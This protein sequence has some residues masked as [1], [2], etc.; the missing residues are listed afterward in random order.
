MKRGELFIAGDICAWDVSAQAFIERLNALKDEGYTAFTVFIASD[1]GDV[2]QAIAIYNELKALDDVR[3]VV[4]GNAFSAASFIAMASDD[5]RMTNNS[6]MLIHNPWSWGAGDAA[7]MKKVADELEDI[8]GI[9]V[10]IYE[11]KTGQS[12]EDIRAW[13]DEDKMMNPET[14]KGR[15]FVDEVIEPKNIKNSIGRRILNMVTI[16]KDEKEERTM[17]LKKMFIALFGLDLVAKAADEDVL[18]AVSEIKKVQDKK[19]VDLE[20]DVLALTTERDTL[21][22][23][24]EGFEGKATAALDSQ[25]TTILDTVVEEGKIDVSERPVY[26]AQLKADFEG[27]KAILDKKEAANSLATPIQ[28]TKAGDD[29]DSKIYDL[30]KAS[31]EGLRPKK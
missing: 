19:V 6:R 29:D 21:K 17:D 28:S 7:Y 30:V 12:E 1:G 23:K 31:T 22:A 20:A 25:I 27:T 8:T 16:N 26:E 14:A 15:G 13:M 24:V 9:I 11:E 10:D 18:N 5:V 4:S 3:I 2:F